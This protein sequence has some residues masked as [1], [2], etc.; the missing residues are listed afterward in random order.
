MAFSTTW[1]GTRS[2]DRQ[3]ASAGAQRHGPS[4][5]NCPKAWPRASR[6]SRSSGSCRPGP[7]GQASPKSPQIQLLN[8]AAQPPQP[9]ARADRASYGGIGRNQ[10]LLRVYVLRDEL[11]WLYSIES[12]P[13]PKRLGSTGSNRSSKVGSLPCR[14]S[15]ST[16]SGT[17]IVTHHGS[18]PVVEGINNTVKVIKRCAYDY[19][20]EAYFFLKIH[21]AF[22]SDLQ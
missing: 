13:G 10:S 9:Q 19:R 11:K 22:P 7:A 20:D 4:S 16:C 3:A 21:A 14:C 8:V 15:P 1:A 18:I 17:G 5:N 2:I 6:P 12:S